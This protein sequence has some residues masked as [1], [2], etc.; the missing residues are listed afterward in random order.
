MLHTTG[1]YVRVQD[2]TGKWVNIEIEKCTNEQL[3]QL[4]GITPNKGWVWT[5]FLVSWIQDNMN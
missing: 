4:K 5:K 1:A 2:T 3:N